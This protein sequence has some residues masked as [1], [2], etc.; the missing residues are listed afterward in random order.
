MSSCAPL[1]PV[2]KLP[3]DFLG[4]R[5]IQLLP[6]HLLNSGLPYIL[7]CRSSDLTSVASFWAMQRQQCL[8]QGITMWPFGGHHTCIMPSSHPS[9]HHACTG[10][11]AEKLN[12]QPQTTEYNHCVPP[13]LFGSIFL[14]CLDCLKNEGECCKW[15]VQ[16]DQLVVNV[17]QWV[18]GGFTWLRISNSKAK[19]C[20]HLTMSLQLP[21]V[22]LGYMLRSRRKAYKFFIPT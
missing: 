5:S 13:Y 8:Q 15:C 19:A 16:M 9:L 11:L 21:W 3:W 6:S 14:Q 7:T 12:T 10:I 20:V 1:S 4:P 17:A 2:F 18:A 22:E